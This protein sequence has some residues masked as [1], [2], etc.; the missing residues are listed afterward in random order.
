MLLRSLLCGQVEGAVDGSRRALPDSHQVPGEVD[1]LF[2]MVRGSSTRLSLKRDSLTRFF[3]L[4]FFPQTTPPGPNRDV[5]VQ[6]RFFLLL[7]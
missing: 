5:L 4:G 3:V 2:L 7:G 1:T 6:F